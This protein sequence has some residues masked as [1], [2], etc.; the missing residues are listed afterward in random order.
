MRIVRGSDI[1]ADLAISSSFAKELG[2]YAHG[3]NSRILLTERMSY[4]HDTHNICTINMLGHGV[5]P[6][7]W[8]Y[9]SVAEYVRTRASVVSGAE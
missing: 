2:I 4:W 8:A 6:S 3:L 7:L 9:I 1:R 5:P